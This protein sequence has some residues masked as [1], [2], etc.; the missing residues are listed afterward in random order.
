[1]PVD[2]GDEIGGREAL[3]PGNLFFQFTV[4]PGP[5]ARHR[6][7]VA[8]HDATSLLVEDCD[9]GPLRRRMVDDDPKRLKLLSDADAERFLTRDILEQIV[10]KPYLP[11]HAPQWRFPIVVP[12]A[13]AV[14]R[15]PREPRGNPAASVK[16]E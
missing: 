7:M 11:A 10:T 14:H 16:E 2:E 5:S 4:W 1:V 6:K 15:L 8:E 3:E 12:C 13:C 9:R